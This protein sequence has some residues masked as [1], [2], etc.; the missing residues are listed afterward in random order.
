MSRSDYN[1]EIYNNPIRLLK[2]IN[3]YSLNCQE[4]RYE[5]AIIIDS[6]RTVFSTKQRENE[7]LQD[8]T[9]RFKTL[10]EILEDQSRLSNTSRLCQLTTKPI[11]I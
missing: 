9:R 10:R 11:I 4:I 7:S 8:Y 1:S 3:N 5:M 6:Y 2:A